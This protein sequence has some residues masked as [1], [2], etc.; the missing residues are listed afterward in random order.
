MHFLPHKAISAS[1]LIHCNLNFG[2]FV[3]AD[4]SA[5]L[6]DYLLIGD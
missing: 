3:A 6:I 4:L 2:V 1:S 5:E